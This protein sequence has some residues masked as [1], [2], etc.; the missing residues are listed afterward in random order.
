MHKSIHVN[1]CAFII[2]APMDVHMYGGKM[3]YVCW[4]TCMTV[5][6]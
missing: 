6:M 5:Y 2:Y 1:L 3:L 4:Q